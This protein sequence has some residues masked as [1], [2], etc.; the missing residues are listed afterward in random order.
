MADELLNEELEK[1]DILRER[2]GLGFAEAREL[3]QDCDWDVLEALVVYEKEKQVFTTQWEAKG[4]EVLNKVKQ[5]IKDGNVTHIR[6]MSKG[7]TIAEIPVTVGVVGALIA[8]KLAVLA[9]ATCMLTK[10]TIEF[11]KKGDEDPAEE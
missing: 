10:C 8:P 2:T 6:V 5:L 1:V 9:A 7:R 4:S 11:D 3:L